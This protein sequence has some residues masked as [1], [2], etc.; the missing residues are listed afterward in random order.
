MSANKKMDNSSLYGLGMVALAIIG[1]VVWNKLEP[2]LINWY[3]DHRIQI[4]FV[5]SLVLMVI[6]YR[7]FVWARNKIKSTREL[8]RITDGVGEE[9]VF[10]GYDSKGRKI[11]IRLS[12][13]KMHIQIIGTTN[14]GK[15]ESVIIP[16]SVDDMK[17]RRGFL[18]LDGKSDESLL[19]KIYS[20]AKKYSRLS[21]FKYFSLA[22]IEKSHT[23][24]PLIGGT[25]EEITERV[26]NAFT[27]ENEF[28]KAV[29]YEVFSQIMRLFESTNEIPTFLK[30]Y[31]AIKE[32]ACLQRLI[33][34]CNNVSLSAWATRFMLM[35]AED[36]EQKTVG[37]TSQISQFAFGSTAKLFNVENPSINLYEVLSK[38]QLVYFQLPVLRM[39][40]LGKATGKLVLQ[41]LNAAVSE[42]HKRGSKNDKFF[43]VYL[44]DF[45]EFIPE[46]FTSL[47]N[48]S[49]SA[50]V[51]VTFAHQAMGDLKALG[52]D[53]QNTILVNSNLKVFMR[54]NEPDS[55]EYFSKVVGTKLAQKVTE[56]QSMKMLGPQKSGEGTVRDVEQFVYHPNVFKSELGV[57]EAVML[58]PHENGSHA[59]RLKFSMLPDL[60]NCTIP[61]FDKPDPVGLEIAEV[62]PASNGV[63]ELVDHHQ[64]THGV[65]ESV[66]SGKVVA[67]AIALLSLVILC[68]CA[69]K[70][71]KTICEHETGYANTRFL[72][73]GTC[74]K[75]NRTITG[76]EWIETATEGGQITQG[77][78]VLQTLAKQKEGAK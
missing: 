37:L 27:F 44:D 64:K 20:Y 35:K 3:L 39:P 14:A 66:V 31:E 53:I 33:A 15:T 58:I 26:F 1:V 56:R 29:Q 67:K 22:D 23:F 16:L 75:T 19:S 78:F 7:I 76:F 52:D 30:V 17:F 69:S 73:I 68:S 42:R 36:R 48:K 12:A 77:H 71:K 34:K 38:N 28:Y 32:P 62:G 24:N 63:N 10:V 54:T 74:I 72:L 6:F 13:R 59:V 49:R 47:L 18:M 25:P 2:R 65:V 40:S 46:T 60:P 21:Q 4:A 8:R 70:P 41:C 11:H 55:A 5:I 57:G 9:S 50:N 45:S 51:G 61:D 43:S